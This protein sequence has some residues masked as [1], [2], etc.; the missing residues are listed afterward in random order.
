ML[1]TGFDSP[2]L[3]AMY[4]DQ[5]LKEHTLLQAIARVNRPLDERKTHGLIID[6][7][8]ISKNLREAFELYDDRDIE[9]VLKPTRRPKRAP[10]GLA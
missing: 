7:W 3:Q 10:K 2:I 5:G 8:G 1:L 6:Y 9:N 4:L